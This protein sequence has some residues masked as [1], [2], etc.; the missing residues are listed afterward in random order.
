MRKE[1]GRTVRELDV[2]RLICNLSLPFFFEA[3]PI[4][5]LL[6]LC[7]SCV[8]LSCTPTS[9]HSIQLKSSTSKKLGHFILKKINTECHSWPD[10]NDKACQD[11]KLPLNLF[12]PPL[13]YLVHIIVVF[14]H[15]CKDS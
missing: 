11:R 14:H 9:N 2:A 13:Q 1:T 10:I 15:V 12:S 5:L 3:C 8:L 7:P 4:Q 6:L